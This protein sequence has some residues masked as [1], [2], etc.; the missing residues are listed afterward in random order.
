MALIAEYL[1]DEA[2]GAV[3][4]DSQASPV[5]LDIEPG[6]SGAWDSIAAGAGYDFN[7][8]GEAVSAN[9]TSSNKIWQA[10]NSD[11]YT[12]ITV[13]RIDSA[14]AAS[15]IWGIREDD[16]SQS[17]VRTRR[18]DSGA[19]A[20]VRWFWT[21]S[22]SWISA[23]DIIPTGDICIMAQVFDSSNGTAAQRCR[24]YL[25][26][27]GADFAQLTPA[28][29][30]QPSSGQTPDFSTVTNAVFGLSQV[31]GIPA[32]SGALFYC[33]LHDDAIDATTL[34]ALFTALRA[35]ND[36][37]PT[38]GGGDQTISPTGISGAAAFQTHTLAPGAVTITPST[39]A[40]AA[41]FQTHTL[42]PGAVT[43]S[44][45]ELAGTGLLGSHSLG[46]F[47]APTGLAGNAQFQTHTLVPGAVA[48]VP[49]EL[50]GSGL[51]G[52]HTTTVYVTAGELAG[53]GTFQTHALVPG[54]VALSPAEIEGLGLLGTHLLALYLAPVGVAGSAAFQT[55]ALVPGA[56]GITPAE[57]E[58]AG[59]LGEHDV[60]QGTVIA[61][62][63]IDGSGLFGSHTLVP[64]GVTITHSP[65]AGAGL[66]GAHVL[67][68]GTVALEPEGVTGAAAFQTH[69]VAPGAA[70]LSVP[71]LTGQGDIQTPALQPGEVVLFPTEMAG[72][73]LVSAPTLSL[74]LALSALDG[75]GLFDSHTIAIGA[76]SILPNAL[77]GQ[78]LFVNPAIT[79]G[80]QF[81]NA[82]L[83]TTE[84]FLLRYANE[85]TMALRYSNSESLEV[86]S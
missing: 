3:A 19:G 54:A 57:I 49:T 1:L 72:A 60:F 8:T 15:S 21:Q 36:A 16:F 83:A 77:V 81:A 24:V 61:P 39:I 75:S 33:A 53:A 56:V 70:L 62:D 65:L 47:L 23:N 42:A 43:L 32:M 22:G 2:T 34:Q 78:G 46:L 45:S 38:A 35:D 31:I 27:D 4:G 82:R 86:Q 51:L 25:D 17:P 18:N 80:A 58:G 52:S 85:E 28:S 40:G 50:A 13:F 63:A 59:E 48:I 71:T 6:A 7:A 66:L 10:L 30:D 14:T 12:V 68:P 37:T 55:H 26:T 29:F 84:T 69:T 9:I 44:P 5:D 73:G 64:G 20:G 67:S 79:G 11:T 74:Y 41:A 76:A